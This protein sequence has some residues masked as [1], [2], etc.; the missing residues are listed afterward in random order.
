[1]RDCLHRGTRHTPL[2]QK[3]RKDY[4]KHYPN[5]TDCWQYIEVS[6]V[7]AAK[8]FEVKDKENDD[9]TDAV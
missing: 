4:G 5:N 6:R 1:M 8:V 3:C 2:C 9:R 7:K